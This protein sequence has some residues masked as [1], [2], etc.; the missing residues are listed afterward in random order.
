MILGQ[1]SAMNRQ[2]EHFLTSLPI[3]NGKDYDN[4]SSQMMIILCYQ[5]TWDLVKEGVTP[6]AENA[7]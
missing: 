6:I 3:L 4:W 1:H 7:T 5:D 2:N